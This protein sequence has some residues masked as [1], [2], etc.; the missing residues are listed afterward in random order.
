MSEQNEQSKAGMGLGIA[1]FVLGIISLI[2]SF[3]PCLG[4]YAVYPG[5]IA[6]ILSAIALSQATKANAARGLIIAALIISI[7]GASIAAYQ[8]YFW[9]NAAS[10]MVDQLENID[11]FGADF[12]KALND[13]NLE[14]DLQALENELNESLD[15]VEITINGDTTKLK[16]TATKK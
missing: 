16:V 11:D 14:E 13:A 15:S 12:E 4:M 8:M 6:V 3:I 2:I 9:S 7:V 10:E 5:I 1:G